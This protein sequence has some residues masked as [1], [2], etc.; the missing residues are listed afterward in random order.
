[1]IGSALFSIHV[2]TSLLTTLIKKILMSPAELKFSSSIYFSFH[3][4]L[5]SKLSGW[6]IIFFKA[7]CLPVRTRPVYLWCT[8]PSIYQQQPRHY[9]WSGR[10][11]WYNTDTV[12][13]ILFDHITA[14]SWNRFR[15]TSI[16]CSLTASGQIV[17]THLTWALWFFHL[18]SH[19]DSSPHL[20][21]GFLCFHQTS[22]G[23][24]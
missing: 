1:M 10:H 22:Q 15:G 7:K 13:L 21:C 6:H 17:H 3:V 18:F 4:S 12:L 23:I 14:A 11:Q 16:N 20:F 2:Y 5:L 19:T 24:D 8:E 9:L